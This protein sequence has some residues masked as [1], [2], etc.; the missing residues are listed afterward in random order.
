MLLLLL[1]GFPRVP[2]DQPEADVDLTNRKQQSPPRG[3]SHLLTPPPTLGLKRPGASC[4]RCTSTQAT[5]TEPRSTKAAF[6]VTHS[7]REKDSPPFSVN[8]SISSGLSGMGADHLG[9][10]PQPHA[11]LQPACGAGVSLH[12]G[13]WLPAQPQY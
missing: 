7:S 12:R 9:P 6:R 11:L 3:P 1:R 5:I 10:R 4:S 13:H 2:P 8:L